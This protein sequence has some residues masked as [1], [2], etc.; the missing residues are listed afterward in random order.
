MTALNVADAL[1]LGTAAV[2]KLYLGNDVVWE[3]PSSGPTYADVVLADAPRA[4]YRLNDAAGPP[5]P[6]ASA[7]SA[8][9]GYPA[10]EAFDGDTRDESAWAAAAVGPAWLQAQLAAPGVMTHYTLGRRVGYLLQAPKTWT[11]KGSNDGVTWTV[12]DTR[13][14]EAWASDATRSFSFSNSTAYTYYRLDV[15]EWRSNLWG[16]G[17]LDASSNGRHG[18]YLG[19]VTLGAA[20]LLSDDTDPAA[21]FTNGQWGEVP[22]D[23]WMEPTA[24]ITYEAWV[25]PSSVAAG[26]KMIV[27]KS[28]LSSFSDANYQ[29]YLLQNGVTGFGFTLK[30]TSGS[31]TDLITPA[32]T[33]VVGQ[34]YHVVGTYDGAFMRL[35]VDG[36][37]VA[38]VAKTGA[39]SSGSNNPLRIGH[40]N[41]P[42][43]YYFRGTIDEVALYGSALSPARVSAHYLAGKAQLSAY[44]TEVLADAPAIYWKAD[45]TT[46]TSLADRA[47][48]GRVATTFTSPVLGSAPL[49]VDHAAARSVRFDG[50]GDSIYRNHESW[51]TGVVTVEGWFAVTG[52]P[53]A[54]GDHT[55]IAKDD[56]SVSF[57][58]RGWR[59]YYNPGTDTLSW[60]GFVG[61]TTTRFTAS[62]VGGNPLPIGGPPRHIVATYDGTVARLYL[63]GVEV[64]THTF[65]A[66]NVRWSTYPIQ[67]GKDSGGNQYQ[68]NGKADEIAVYL[69]V[70]TPER[71]LAH[72]GAA[73]VDE[74][75]YSHDF[76]T[77]LGAFTGLGVQTT[78]A[79]ATGTSK[80]TQS[81]VMELAQVNPAPSTPYVAAE[82]LFANVPALT[83]RTLT[84]VVVRHA[85]RHLHQQ[86]TTPRA[87]TFTLAHGGGTGYSGGAAN[88]DLN[89]ENL[90]SPWLETE[91][92]YP[93]TF[94][95][96]SLSFAATAADMTLYQA[97]TD[98][99]IYAA[100]L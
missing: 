35:Y 2:D 27:S 58:S 45:V 33:L 69:T 66:A 5:A 86:N 20:G 83:G 12:L 9:S 68:L 44:A 24:A 60:S 31:P 59:L 38:S 96:A 42:G 15:T 52:A 90:T 19:G 57:A 21:S 1:R 89:N 50:A 41:Q 55:L 80:P 39:V 75:I 56:V 76:S 70:L 64:A 100:P 48:F 18:S 62:Y 16:T 51:M 73:Q 63:D 88:M 25:K 54:G 49:V 8:Y 92:A 43:D 97:I 65:G 13:T 82:L 37:L 46:G 36:Q 84:R 67:V 23:T 81:H 99:R 91:I 94:L 74:L 79:A 78:M 3:P 11:M 4:Y 32:M 6:T 7:S 95:R 72:Y 30:T 85:W 10:A 28:N 22:R 26:G 34:T 17:L 87:S 14:N 71:I 61:A 29:G 40:I 53:G 47:G 77:G 98:V 93:E